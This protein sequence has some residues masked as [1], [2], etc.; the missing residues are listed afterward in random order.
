MLATCEIN[1]NALINLKKRGSMPAADT[2][3]LIAQYLDVSVEYLMGLTDNPAPPRKTITDEEQLAAEI[4]KMSPEK[5]QTLIQ[6]AEFLKTQTDFAR[7]LSDVL[8]IAGREP[9]PE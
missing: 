3:A 4:F 8:D 9:L 1:K 5:R 6:Y 7:E 2:M